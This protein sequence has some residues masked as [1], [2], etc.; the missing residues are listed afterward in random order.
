METVFSCLN[1]HFGEYANPAG[2]VANWM[3]LVNRNGKVHAGSLMTLAWTG[4]MEAETFAV[5]A[6]FYGHSIMAAD[7][8]R[9]CDDCHL[10]QALLDLNANGNLKLATWEGSAFENVQGVIP[11]PPAPAG[12]SVPD[13][14]KSIFTVD[15]VEWDGAE[16]D[17]LEEGPDLFQMM[18]EYA[19]PLTQSQ[20]DKLNGWAQS[21][22]TTRVGKETWYQTGQD[23]G[24]EPGYEALTGVPYDQLACITCHDKTAFPNWEK[25]TCDDCHGSDDLDD[26]AGPAAVADG[27]CLGCHGRQGAEI[28]KHSFSDV[29][30]D[31]TAQG[32]P[33]TCMGCHTAGDVHGDGNDYVSMLDDGAIDADCETCHQADAAFKALNA[34]HA[35]HAGDEIHCDACHM[36]A[37]LSCINCHFKDEVDGVGKWAHTQVANW[38]YLVNRDGMVHA[39]TLMTL[40]YRDAQD[41]DQTF[42]LFAPY[43]AHNIKRDAITACADCHNSQNVQDIDAADSDNKI[44]LM[45]WDGGPKMTNPLSGIIPIPEGFKDKFEID[46]VQIATRNADQSPATWSYLETG[47]DAW[48]MIRRYGM[49]LNAV[50]WNWLKIAVGE[51]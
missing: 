13:W 19:A 43:Y 39:A 10:S 33:T 6:P 9:D 14:L 38:K 47:P 2:K 35:Q 25:P 27:T 37:S 3:Y 32:A 30:R 5:I 50:Q 18:E 48:Q 20:F 11:V 31:S 46:F 23:A 17:F 16:W 34:F 22:H 24:D 42:A 4:D 45:E 49:P 51:P 44:K 1:C 21:L 8:A 29:H 15:F 7:D 26:L 12:T 40:E 36:Q 41:N 28:N